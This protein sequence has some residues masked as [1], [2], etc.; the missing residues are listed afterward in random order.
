MT[1]TTDKK[2][3]TIFG[4]IVLI[5]GWIS[6]FSGFAGVILAEDFQF[7]IQVEDF[8]FVEQIIP[9]E[10]II[11]IMFIRILIGFVLIFLGNQII[12]SGG[13]VHDRLC[14]PCVKDVTGK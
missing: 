1:N 13:L 14:H 3:I 6:V 8:L 5:I 12:L 9:A 4:F 11:F 2:L 7:F 10:H